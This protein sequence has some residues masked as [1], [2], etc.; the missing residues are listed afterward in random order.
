MYSPPK[1]KDVM[2]A[3]RIGKERIIGIYSAMII[4][5]LYGDPLIPRV[6]CGVLVQG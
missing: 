1:K 4:T 6:Q 3:W 2:P 5:V